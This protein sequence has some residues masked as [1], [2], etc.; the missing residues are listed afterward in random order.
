MSSDIRFLGL[1][2]FACS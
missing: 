2:L 1:V